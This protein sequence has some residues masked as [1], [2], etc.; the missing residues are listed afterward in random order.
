MKQ[1]TRPV[2]FNFQGQEFTIGSGNFTIMAGPCSIESREHF[3]ETAQG[4]KK[5]GA[6]LLRGGIYKMRTNPDSFQGLGPTA[7]SF[8][9]EVKRA[10]GLPFISEVTDV[11]Q[12]SDMVNF[13][14]MFQVGSRN[15]YNYELL[16]ELG[17]L[18]KPVLLKR[19]FAATVDEWIKAADYIAKGGNEDILL[20][21]RGIRTF[22]PTTRN[23]LDLNSVAYLKS[24]SSF[25]VIVD[26]SHGTGRPELIE[27]L[28]LAAVA[29]GADG[30]IIEVHPRPSE[31]LSDAFQA[32]DFGQFSQLVDHVGKV[33]HALGRKLE[34]FQ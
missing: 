7:F 8:V 32:I 9:P 2:N 6:T 27:P 33:A 4:V 15:M 3:L 34:T 13:V 20:C 23:T 26:P 19:A 25:P 5:A 22:E 17:H 18:R 24:H 28:S 10:V 30:I 21:E 16:R 31:A 11:R 1:Q 14:E 12:L 29:V